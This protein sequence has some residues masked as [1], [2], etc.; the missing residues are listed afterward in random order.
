MRCRDCGA[1]HFADGG[2]NKID[3]LVCLRC[4]ELETR[5]SIESRRHWWI[6]AAWHRLIYTI[7]PWRGSKVDIRK[8]GVVPVRSPLAFLETPV[9]LLTAFLMG[10][11]ALGLPV[12]IVMGLAR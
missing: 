1:S 7:R 8:M 11:C 2:L 4:G 9:M 12:M 10:C 6:I 3:T 5:Q